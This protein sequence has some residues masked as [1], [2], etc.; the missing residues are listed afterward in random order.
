MGMSTHAWEDTWSEQGPLIHLLS[1]RFI[2]G[3]EFHNNSTVSDLIQRFGNVWPD[4]WIQWFP[5]L[6]QIVIPSPSPL[7][8][9]IR[10]LEPNNN[11]QLITVKVAWQ[12]LQEVGPIVHWHKVVWNNAYI[13]KHALCMWMACQKRLPTQDRICQ[14]KHEPPYL[15][16]VFC[17]LVI[18]THNHLLFECDYSSSIWEVIKREIGIQMCPDNWEDIVNMG[19]LQG[20]KLWSTVQKLGISATVYHKWMERNRKFFDNHNRTGAQVVADIKTQI[21]ER[22]AWKTRKKLT[23]INDT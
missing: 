19:I 13:P 9:T 4:E 18:E 7:E 8:D 12:T 11:R 5:Q 6:Q 2:N 3:H 1:Y 14:W 21:L 16:C 20:W 17:N 23:R 10:W 15:K 22:M